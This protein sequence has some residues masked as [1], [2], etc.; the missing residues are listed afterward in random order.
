MTGATGT[1]G[2]GVVPLLKRHEVLTP[3][4]NDLNVVDPDHWTRIV[5][6]FQPEVIVHAAAFTGVDRAEKE[7]AECFQIN[8]NGTRFGVRAAKEVGARFLYISTDYVFDGEKGNYDVD[9]PLGPVNY[10]A[11]T[12][13]LGEFCVLDYALGAIIRTSFAP[14][15]KWR[16]PAAFEDLWTGKDYIS[17]LAPEYA[18]AIQMPFTGV[19]HIATERKSV[20]ELVKRVTPDIQPILRSSVSW[21]L[22]RDVSLNTRSWE[23]AKKCWS[24]ISRARGRGRNDF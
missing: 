22:P 20:F 1:F 21:P 4:R 15:G 13:T 23:F 7:R 17:V 9:D 12:K 19:V 16:Y 8:V 10:Y 18:L 24:R 3:S 2:R 5:D 11:L 6:L 14:D